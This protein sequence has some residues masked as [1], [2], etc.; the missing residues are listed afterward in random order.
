VTTSTSSGALDGLRGSV[1]RPGDPGY[2]QGVVGFNL[3][4]VHAPALVVEAA[5]AADVAAAVRYAVAEG[6]GVSVQST[7]HGAVHPAGPDTLLLRTGAMDTVDVDPGARTATV[8]AGATIGQVVGACAPHGLAPVTGSAPAVGA[9]GLTLGGGIGPLVR[10]LGFAADRVRGFD[11]VTADGVPRHVDANSEPDLFFALRGGGGGF[12]VVTSMTVDL[13]EL[14]GFWGGAVFFPGADAAAVLHAWRTWA[15]ALPEEM[16]T[17]VALL[18][19]PPLP[20]LP[21]PLRGQYVL[22][23][24]IASTGSPEDGGTRLE[25]LLRLSTP[26]MNTVGAL[27]YEAI[28]AVHMDLTDPLPFYDRGCLLGEFTG[29]AVDALLAVGPEN[30][31]AVQVLEVRSLGGAMARQPAV[32]DAVGARNARWSCV[33][34]GAL[35][36]EPADGVPVAVDA[37]MDAVAPWRAGTMYNLAVGHDL[38][39]AWSADVLARLQQITRERDPHGLFRP[40]QPVPV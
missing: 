25:P 29:G 18:R 30:S 14:T 13:L 11:V 3:A 38:T 16:T 12:A 33:A 21:E 17:S 39:E 7:G 28:G 22:Q 9:V 2:H 24:R 8:G 35:V 6:L 31:A 10:S 37:V 15:P 1:H 40:A 27:P 23:L 5:D 34:V 26:V 19:F 32:P 36:P 4:V 20:G